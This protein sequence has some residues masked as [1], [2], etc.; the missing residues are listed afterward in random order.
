MKIKKMLTCDEVRDIIVT[1]LRGKGA[2]SGDA[3]ITDVQPL[4]SGVDTDE[5]IDIAF[6][7]SWVE[8]VPQ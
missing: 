7:A 8:K 3:D 5:R 2:I 1:Y 6:V 4:E